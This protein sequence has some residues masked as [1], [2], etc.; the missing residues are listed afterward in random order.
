M[1][2]LSLDATAQGAIA[3]WGSPLARV[4]G[5]RDDGGPATS[6][7]ILE[8][9]DRELLG[10]MLRW[11]N[12]ERRPVTIRGSGTKLMRHNASKRVDIVLS[13]ARLT[14]GLDHVPGDLTVSTPAGA[15]LADVNRLLA[16]ERQW[17]PLDPRLT[18]E[19]T[20]GGIVA[21]NDS[22]PRRHQHGTP[23]DLII[24]I[25][26]VLADGRTVKAG[27]RVVK[28]VAGYDLAR[29]L[30]GSFGSL[31]V[32][33]RA[34]F[35][36]APLPATSRTVIVTSDQLKPLAR[37]ATTIA[38]SALTPS[39]IEID[40]EPPRLLIRIDST[41]ASA[42]HQALA[43]STMGREQGMTATIA[44]QETQEVSWREHA[45]VLSSTDG[46]LIKV[47]VLPI[48]VVDLFDCIDRVT[49]RFS[50]A[51]QLSGRAALGI[52]YVRLSD[53][54]QPGAD[55]M[56]VRHASAVEELRQNA[57]ARGGSAVIVSS[58]PSVTSL[59]DQWGDIGDGLSLMRAVKARFDP[60]HILNPGRGPGGL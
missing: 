54:N 12:E 46:T 13:T 43:A 40:S 33:T 28:N 11:A 18:D 9:T 3:R 29:M 5:E 47:A 6:A 57:W 25:E 1:A 49:T 56:A 45:A 4:A 22:G 55:D 15:R 53:A 8:P 32:I 48:Q 10:D 17:L 51:Y 2:P 35:K 23:R 19:A 34:T 26:A 21:T 37:L 52:L 31:A 16:R 20:I 7:V 58:S 24:G 50:L 59:V 14:E 44:S 38:G 27:G 30:C 60:H 36:L 41:E 39:A 42:D